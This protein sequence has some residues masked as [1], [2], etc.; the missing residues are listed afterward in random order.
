MPSPASQARTVDDALSGLVR[1]TL[2]PSAGHV[3]V[4]ADFN[5]I[6]LRGTAW[7]AGETRLLAQFAAR[8]NV[9]CEMASR[10]FGRAV[11]KADKTERNVGKVTCLGAGYSMGAPTFA[12]YCAGQGIDLAAA[13]SSAS[14]CIE[15]FRDAYPAIA[16]RPAGVLDGKVLRR[17][18]SGRTTRQRPCGR[19]WSG[20]ACRPGAAC[21]SG[22]ARISS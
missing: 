2:V 14:A 19:C 9:Y 3:L 4:L 17:G 1:L 20:P 21:S 12:L 8:R 5:A 7:V 15:A 18:A 22:R 10:I 16:G 6:E 11:V 13:H